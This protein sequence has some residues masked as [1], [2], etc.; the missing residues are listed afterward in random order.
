MTKEQILAMIHA[1]VDS[2]VTQY[3]HHRLPEGEP[4]ATPPAQLLEDFIN[5]TAYAAYK[6]EQ[7]MR[8]NQL[9][10]AD[11]AAVSAYLTELSFIAATGRS[12]SSRQKRSEIVF[13]MLVSWLDRR[14]KDIL[15][16][17]KARGI[18]MVPQ[19]A[20]DQ[21]A[22]SGL[23][24]KL[25]ATDFALY[26]LLSMKAGPTSQGDLLDQYVEGLA[27][28]AGHPSAAK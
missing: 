4:F 17:L 7:V 14:K 26:G 15:Q 18:S 3:G 20:L 9:V 10:S 21:I 11:P 23:S 1:E 5:M 8:E 13:F 27:V 16:S 12:L 25:V 22:D 28:F 19:L 6:A 24:G 2:I